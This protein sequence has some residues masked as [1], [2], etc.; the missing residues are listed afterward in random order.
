VPT[1]NDLVLPEH[2]REERERILRRELE[3]AYATNRKLLRQL[4]QAQAAAEEASRAH[5]KMVSTLTETMRENITLT[6][7]RDIWRARALRQNIYDHA[8]VPDL[9]ALLGIHDVTEAEVRAIRK[10]MARLHHPDSGG[11]PERMKAWNA[12]LD[13]IIEQQH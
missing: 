9:E 6:N 4:K 5:T 8:P 11:D 7:E 13:L 10:T 1:L 2:D 3:A 12:A